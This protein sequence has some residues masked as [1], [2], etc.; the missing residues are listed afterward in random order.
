MLLMGGQRSTSKQIGPP[1]YHPKVHCGHKVPKG[2][3]RR[4]LYADLEKLHTEE[5][6]LFLAEIPSDVESIQSDDQCEGENFVECNENNFD[7]ENIEIVYGEDENVCEEDQ[8]EWE[9]EDNIPLC[10]I[11]KELLNKKYIWSKDIKYCNILNRFTEDYGPNIPSDC[12]TP[13]D[14]LLIYSCKYFHNI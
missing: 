8:Y 12:E 14:I 2:K 3:E 9:E 1:G 10:E 4:Y 11:Q 7:I 13:I 5:F 6:Q